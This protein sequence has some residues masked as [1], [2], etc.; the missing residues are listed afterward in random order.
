[1]VLVVG[2]NAAGISR[3]QLE[4]VS[5]MNFDVA[6]SS[7]RPRT[8]GALSPPVFQDPILAIIRNSVPSAAEVH[9]PNPWETTTSMD[10]VSTGASLSHP[11]LPENPANPP[12]TAGIESES[13]VLP[14]PEPIVAAQMTSHISS[15]AQEQ[16]A[17]VVTLGRPQSLI[18]L[19]DSDE[20]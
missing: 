13:Q 20:E 3:T 9:S 19:S 10:A 1:M 7:P 18:Y 14:D 4:T 12:T 17:N 15:G 2:I 16:V 6:Q 5:E 8:S 11:Y